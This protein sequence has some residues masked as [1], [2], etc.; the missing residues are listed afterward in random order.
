MIIKRSEGTIDSIYKDKESAQEDVEKKVG[1]QKED[2][3]KED[4]K[5][6]EGN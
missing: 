4:K 1:V 2:P 3:A 5:S 6:D